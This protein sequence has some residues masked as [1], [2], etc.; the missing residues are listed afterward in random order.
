MLFVSARSS[1]TSD[2][3]WW[4]TGR[5]DEAFI[6]PNTKMKGSTLSY[7]KQRVSGARALRNVPRKLLEPSDSLTW[8]YTTCGR[9][10]VVC[11]WLFASFVHALKRA[12]NLNWG[13]VVFSPFVFWCHVYNSFYTHLKHVF[14]WININDSSC[15]WGHVHKSLLLTKALFLI[16][17][18][19]ETFVQ[20]KIAYIC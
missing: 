7:Q 2:S 6:S 13:F 5:P 8:C 17:K 12:E 11:T 10:T 19:C 16:K 3:F 14:M 20:F 15:M 18:N 1:E 9:E 4:V